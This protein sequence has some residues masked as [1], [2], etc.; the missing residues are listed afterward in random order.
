M[1]D[2]TKTTHFVQVKG[3]K[4]KDYR[5]MV[6]ASS[7]KEAFRL[8][9]EMRKKGHDTRV[10]AQ[11]STTTLSEPVVVPERVK[12]K[13]NVGKQ[14]ATAPMKRPATTKVAPKAIAKPA[15]KAT[16]AKPATKPAAKKG[17]TNFEAAAA[18]VKAAKGKR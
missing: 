1:A 18:A 14:A 17:S 7:P 5:N 2:V 11:T 15:A 16:Q 4:D 13:P 10:V 3:P 8:S 12:P 6:T 9:A